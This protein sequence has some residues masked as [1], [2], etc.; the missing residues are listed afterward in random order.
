ML[1]GLVIALIHYV[2]LGKDLPIPLCLSFSNCSIRELVSLIT[3]GPF[4]PVM[5][6]RTFPFMGL[7]SLPLATSEATVPSFVCPS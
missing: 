5:P 3:K 2:T 4:H 6:V 7:T 1:L